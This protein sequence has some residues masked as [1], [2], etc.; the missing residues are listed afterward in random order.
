MS[1][2]STICAEDNSLPDEAEWIEA[3]MARVQDGNTWYNYLVS[4]HENAMNDDGGEGL[5]IPDISEIEITLGEP[6]DKGH[7]TGTISWTA[8]V[9]DKEKLEEQLEWFIGD[10]M[11]MYEVCDEDEG[12]HCYVNPG[13]FK[14]E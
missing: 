1:F 5:P 9:V 12:W 6:S 13:D 3:A 11:C 14:A 10:R 4:S 8:E 7:F 2:P